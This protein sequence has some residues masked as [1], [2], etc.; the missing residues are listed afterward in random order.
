VR[1]SPAKA[2]AHPSFFVDPAMSAAGNFGH[3]YATTS[4]ANDPQ[5]TSPTDGLLQCNPDVL[6]L[7]PASPHLAPGIPLIITTRSAKHDKAAQ[8]A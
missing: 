1:F 7:R 8:I 6:K 4:V 5:P 2:I 3:S